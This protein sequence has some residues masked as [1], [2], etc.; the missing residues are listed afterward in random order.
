VA[1]SS[2][3]DGQGRAELL[4]RSV[5]NNPSIKIFY[6]PS[7]LIT[8]SVKLTY[9]EHSQCRG[10]TYHPR[11]RRLY[12]SLEH[13]RSLRFLVSSATTKVGASL[14]HSVD[15]TLPLMASLWSYLPVLSLYL[16]ADR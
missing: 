7:V 6:I 14:M 5:E 2:L 16:S 8:V 15:I 10:G 1:R 9:S 4:I 11:I 13:D 3:A 12:H